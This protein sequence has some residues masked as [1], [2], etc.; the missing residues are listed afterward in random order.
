[1]S[2]SSVWQSCNSGLSRG[3]LWCSVGQIELLLA[4]HAQ[5]L[6]GN[7]TGTKQILKKILRSA[8]TAVR[9]RCAKCKPLANCRKLG[10]LCGAGFHAF[11]GSTQG[12]ARLAWR[13]FSSPVMRALPFLD[14]RAVEGEPKNAP[15]KN[16][17]RSAGKYSVRGCWWRRCDWRADN[18]LF[19]LANFNLPDGKGSKRGFA[20][21]QDLVTQCQ[22]AWLTEGQI[23]RLV[24]RPDDA[25]PPFE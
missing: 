22:F 23:D 8:G 25:P 10:E 18:W 5:N 12:A 2:I 1:M 11:H 21:R 13:T 14:V 9:D 15:F 3:G 20:G 6:T 24:T 7:F 4:G 19:V 17:T 16:I